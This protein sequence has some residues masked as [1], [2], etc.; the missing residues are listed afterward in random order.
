MGARS[1][2]RRVALACLIVSVSLVIPAGCAS[3][4]VRT[5]KTGKEPWYEP[6][7]HLGDPDFYGWDSRARQIERNVGIG[8]PRD[9]R[10]PM[11]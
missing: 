10:T 1:W 6:L 7:L 4:A 8:D 2:T 9:Q 11:Q 3:R 5:P